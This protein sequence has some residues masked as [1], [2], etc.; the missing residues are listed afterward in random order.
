MPQTKRGAT[1]SEW[2][3]HL[4][5]LAA[6]YREQKATEKTATSQREEVRKAVEKERRKAD[7]LTSAF[8]ATVELGTAS[9]AKLKEEPKAAAA[10]RRARL[11]DALPKKHGDVDARAIEQVRRKRQIAAEKA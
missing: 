8:A 10:T 11:K 5:G 6:V 7:R 3:Q 4:Q 1:K 9:A 2:L